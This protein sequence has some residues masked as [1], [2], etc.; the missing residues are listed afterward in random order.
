MSLSKQEIK[1]YLTRGY[2]VVNNVLSQEDIK[3]V[4]REL[5]TEI[6]RRTQIL[7]SQD[8]IYDLYN[9]EPFKSRYAHLYAQ[10]SEIAEN[11]EITELR[12]QALFNLLCHQK[13]LDT[14]DPLLGPDIILNPSHNLR[15][16]VPFK[17]ITSERDYDTVP[18]HQ[19]AFLTTKETDPFDM[20]TVWIPLVDATVENGCLEV[21][22]EAFKMGHLQ[23]QPEGGYTIKKDQLPQIKGKPLPCKKG[24]IILMNKY[25]PHRSTPNFS[26]T[27]RW[28]I[29]VRY[30]KTGTPT[31]R[32]GYPE[33]IVRKSHEQFI[34]SNYQQWCLQ[35]IKTLDKLNQ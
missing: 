11:L 32:P 14:I 34:L 3:P 20:V 33:F 25:T 1:S 4:I 31:G 12:S 28:S 26:E 8:K 19:D 27:V 6:E 9:Y 7:F 23:H 2:L 18:W 35:W 5:K 22:P 24:S 15:A 17:L 16:K 29:D 13:I 30:Q 10:C 21:M